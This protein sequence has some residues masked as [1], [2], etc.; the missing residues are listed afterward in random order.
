MMSEFIGKRLVQQHQMT[1][2]APA[3]EVFP[4]LCPKREEDWLD[5]WSYR[6]IHSESGY[7]ETGCVFQ[8]DFPGEGPS[9]WLAHKIDPV[10]HEGEYI[11]FIP[12]L[13]IATLK[14]DV[15]A[16]TEESIT[17]NVT[18]TFIGLSDYGNIYA[19]R[20]SAATPALT[21]F[22]EQSLNHYVK[23]GTILKRG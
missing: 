6:M 11:R 7:A 21:G 5:G 4:L 10:N 22:L 8:T 20:E 23:T 18:R 13:A 2:H 15:V 9:V 3:S 19:E 16:K 12:N 17:Y 1:V 14:F